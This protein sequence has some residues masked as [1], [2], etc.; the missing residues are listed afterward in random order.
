VENELVTVSPDQPG[1]AAKV[2]EAEYAAGRYR[3]EPPLSFVVDILCAAPAHALIG[4]TGV[5]I[6]CGNGPN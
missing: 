2:W 1:G 5:Y 4:E 3:D 6:G